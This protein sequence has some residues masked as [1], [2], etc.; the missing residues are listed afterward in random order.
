LTG[1]FAAIDN[2]QWSSLGSFSTT[3]TGNDVNLVW[4]AVPEP[5][6]FLTG[7]VFATA[8]LLRRRRAGQAAMT[9]P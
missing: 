2:T 8:G 7:G 6:C 3:Y 4:T 1:S 5:S 9:N